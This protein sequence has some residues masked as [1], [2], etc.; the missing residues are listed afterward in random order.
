MRHGW[1]PRIPVLGLLLIVVAIQG[2]S[3]DAHDLASMQPLRLIARIAPG[4]DT[5][6]G[7]DEWPDDVCDPVRSAFALSGPLAHRL[8]QGSTPYY[9]PTIIESQGE[10]I[11]C[12]LFRR[13]ARPGQRTS[14][15]MPLCTIGCLLC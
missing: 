9:N 15:A 8:D 14:I 5:F 10:P 6:A 11:S 7:E 4:S 2:I 13:R 12:S 1:L 3:P